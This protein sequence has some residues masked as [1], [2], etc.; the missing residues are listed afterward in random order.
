[1]AAS[2]SPRT[3]EDARGDN[4][5]VVGGPGGP[6]PTVPYTGM[7]QVTAAASSAGMIPDSSK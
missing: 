3:S 4:V 7:P 6:L 2:L 1:M 5:A